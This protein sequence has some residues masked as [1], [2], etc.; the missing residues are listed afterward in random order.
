MKYRTKLYL[1]LISIAVLSTV[2][3]L[4]I[5]SIESE[6]MV[7][8]LLRS[9]TQSIVA[10]AAN[11][12]DPDLIEKL[13]NPEMQDS[14]LYFQVRDYL[15]KLRNSNRRNDVYVNTFYT[16]FTDPK[17]SN[18]LLYSIDTDREPYLLGARYEDPDKEGILSH[19]KRNY[20]Y[21]KFIPDQ[22]GVW[23]SAFSP[24]FDKEGNYVA[25]LGVDVSAS[26]IHTRMEKLIY[27]G[28]WALVFSAIAAAL[29]AFI[30]S[31]KVTES[32]DYICGSVR[33][34]GEGN[35]S[36]KA[37]IETEDEFG[38]LAD[39]INDMTK[40]LQERER[41]KMG[42]ARYVSKHILERILRS[43]TPLKLEGERRKITVLFS[44][45]RQF[46]H[47]AE[48]LPAEQVVSILNEYFEKMIEIIFSHFGTLDKFIG[49]GI[50]AEFG[51]PLDDPDQEKHAVDAAI[52]MQKTLTDLCEKWKKEGKPGFQVGIGIHTGEAVVGNIGSEKRIEYTAIGDTVNVAARL[53]QM[54]KVTHKPI[55]I[56]ETTFQKAKDHFTYKDLGAVSLPGRKEQIRVYSIEDNIS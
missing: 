27:Y 28:I 26:D 53:E 2:L 48:T 40:G 25:T 11:S 44:D 21:P 46:T 39:A 31:K 23:L 15:I 47:L 38:E 7:F 51:A 9:Q 10:T 18:E 50:M 16:V 5:L 8:D 12:L 37:E 6:K 24:I 35:L 43:D 49:D 36:V 29:A 42:F 52:Q 3:A 4:V 22:W 45:I 14:P 20:I 41:L 55:L 32:L 56:S 19:L 13:K 33:Q 1:A 30:L 54:T 34:I 17:N